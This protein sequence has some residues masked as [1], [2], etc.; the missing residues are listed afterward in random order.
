M[1]IPGTDTRVA[2]DPHSG[3]DAISA[4]EVKQG[5]DVMRGDQALGEAQQRAREYKVEAQVS[6][7]FNLYDR[8]VHDVN[9]GRSR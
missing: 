6:A 4:S 9:A 8:A 2:H 3:G 1:Q 7:F 5:D